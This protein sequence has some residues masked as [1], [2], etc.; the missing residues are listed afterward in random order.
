MIVAT[1]A[2]GAA[3]EWETYDFAFAIDRAEVDPELR[4][5]RPREDLRRRWSA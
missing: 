3:P 5:Q 1:G 2:L 4:R